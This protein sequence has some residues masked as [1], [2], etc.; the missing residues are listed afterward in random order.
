MTGLISD[1]SAQSPIRI[2]LY[3]PYCQ[4]QKLAGFEKSRASVASM[5]VAVQELVANGGVNLAPA[6]TK[7]ALYTAMQVGARPASQRKLM[8]PG[9]SLQ[10][11]G[12][13]IDAAQSFR[14]LL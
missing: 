7:E 8:P 5:A 2:P 11:G 9:S 1:T 4:V 14:Q 10:L 12:Q 13:E 3:H 6:A